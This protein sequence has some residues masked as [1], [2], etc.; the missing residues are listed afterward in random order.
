M[1]GIIA[2][3]VARFYTQPL[4]DGP[5]SF[6]FIAYTTTLVTSVAALAV[7]VTCS[8]TIAGQ[9]PVINA[10]N[11]F[12][13]SGLTGVRTGNVYRIT[14]TD[15]T[16]IPAGTRIDV[17]VEFQV[18]LGTN[19]AALTST[20]TPALAVNGST[21]V[22]GTTI[23]VP[24]SVSNTIN[25]VPSI[26]TI[27]Y[28]QELVISAQF[29]P[30]FIANQNI[31]VSYQI[32][33]NPSLPVNGDSRTT[34]FG[35]PPGSSSTSTT[36][37]GRSA[38]FAGTVIPLANPAGRASIGGTFW[39]S[40]GGFQAPTPGDTLYP[41][42][43]IATVETNP[44]TLQLLAVQQGMLLVAPANPTITPVSVVNATS[45]SISYDIPITP[46][47][48]SP[49]YRAQ[50][51]LSNVFLAGSATPLTV[52]AL[53]LNGTSAPLS[54]ALGT[55]SV[56]TAYVARVTYTFANPTYATSVTANF[57]LTGYS[58]IIAN[59]G[60]V[61]Y[62][63][64]APQVVT[65]IPIANAVDLYNVLSKNNGGVAVYNVTLINRTTLPLTNLTIRYDQITYLGVELVLNSL[66]G[67]GTTSNG[68]IVVTN[69]LSAGARV[70]FV[71]TYDFTTDDY[72]TITGNFTAAGTANGV[73][74]D[75]E[76]VP[77]AYGIPNLDIQN[78]TYGQQI[79]LPLP[80]TPILYSAPTFQFDFRLTDSA[81]TAL[82]ITTVD[83]VIG[84][85]PNFTY[86]AAIF[87]DSTITFTSPVIAP[88]PA[89]L[90][91]IFTPR[92]RSVLGG[93]TAGTRIFVTFYLRSPGAI[94]PVRQ[95]LLIDL[96]SRLVV[97]T[98]LLTNPSISNVA[99]NSLRLTFTIINSTFG[100]GGIISS[101]L[102]NGLMDLLS[103]VTLPGIS[104]PITV[105]SFLVNGAARPIDGSLPEIP[106]TLGYSCEVVYAFDND[107]GAN[108]T[109]TAN[110]SGTGTGNPI[111]NIDTETY[112]FALPAPVSATVP[113][114]IPPPLITSASL[115]SVTYGQPFTITYNFRIEN[116]EPGYTVTTLGSITPGAFT[117]TSQEVD[118]ATTL[119]YTT[120]TPTANPSGTG[121]TFSGIPPTTGRRQVI[122]RLTGYVGVG[123]PTGVLTTQGITYFNNF[124][125]VQIPGNTNISVAQPNPAITATLLSVSATQLSYQVVM[126]N[127]SIKILYE[128]VIDIDQITF[129]NG[130]TNA[131][132]TSVTS[133]VIPAPSYDNNQVIWPIPIAATT[134]LADRSFII[135]Y[136]VTGLVPNTSASANFTL[137]GTSWSTTSVSETIE[138]RSIQ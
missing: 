83:L 53:T 133:G 79:A 128:P 13:P 8:S 114:F 82:P 28:G 9:T 75:N 119:S 69:P 80:I 126:T 31:R 115:T 44:Q 116:I 67:P 101:P 108:Q 134:P 120:A 38:V 76:S 131:T 66:D 35:L 91:I 77:V 121:F 52:T 61:T 42:L 109:F 57:A 4:S 58:N 39:I 87:N 68:V 45:T 46:N 132:V 36:N 65:N 95:Q 113:P 56:G 98:V 130:V 60:S 93:P 84:N 123:S 32:Q 11:I 89:S 112:T 90:N 50:L 135:T 48:T 17:G 64:T 73:P 51:T 29:A 43:R 14:R 20:F 125:A 70:D 127:A 100:S 138:V 63:T 124:P 78:I 16:L 40:P 96:I 15:N 19:P 5:T 18:N 6:A 107:S 27:T 105:T 74:F 94:P 71:L 59:S 88:P 85:S 137:R 136:S 102:Y 129:T 62:S 92:L 3:G 12:T 54:G 86:T 111:T 34:S 33:R 7:S 110:V 10:T 2:Y 41:L 118:P 97:P 122:I 22:N 47:G 99:G 30:L 37:E 26:P 81:M 72:P 55:L 25:G 103:N 23:T 21:F 1:S 104:G 117:V 49:L 106:I 24:Y